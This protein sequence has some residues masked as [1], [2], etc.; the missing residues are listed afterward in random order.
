MMAAMTTFL[1]LTLAVL[2][3]FAVA[4]LLVRAALRGLLAVFA[5]GPVRLPR[6][7]RMARPRHAA[8]ATGT[9]F[10]RARLGESH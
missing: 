5:A 8:A 4:L 9:D 2:L 7:R 10:P 3:S 6:L 1:L